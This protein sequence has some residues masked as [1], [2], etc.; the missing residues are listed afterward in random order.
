MKRHS[1]AL[2]S[3]LLVAGLTQ[4]SGT[5]FANNPGAAPN[6][7]RLINAAFVAETREW[8]ASPVVSMSVEAQNAARGSLDVAAIETLDQQWRAERE[9]DDKPL[10]ASTMSSPLSTYLTR[11]QAGALGLFTEIFVVDANGLNVGQSAITGDYWQG[12]EAKFQNTFPNG[13]D[14]VFID[15]AEWDEDRRIWRA[16]LNLS[17]PSEDG[18]RAIGAATVEVN[19]TELQRRSAG[20]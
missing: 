2:A 3:A 14:A 13:P 19:L 6:P 20:S 11:V 5:A 1:M 9:Q 17:I 12:D 18:T 10:I 8:L 16:Q 4:T 15:E 7:E